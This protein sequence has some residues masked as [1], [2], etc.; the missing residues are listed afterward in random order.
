M[1]ILQ[2]LLFW[3]LT[4]L[5]VA[6]CGTAYQENRQRRAAEKAAEHAAIVRAIE[7]GDFILDVTQIIPRGFPSRTS[8]GEYQLRLEGDVVTTRLPFLGV[9]YQAPNYGDNDD[10]SIVFEK[11]RVTVYRDD[12]KVASKGEYCFQFK[13]GKGQHPWTVTLYVFDSGA[14]TIQCSNTGSRYM[15]YHANLVIPVKNENQ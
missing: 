4:A 1:K 9:S 13:G 6:S 14:A 11:E 10:L 8:T 5:L 12:S 2:R 15:S 7:A 3:A